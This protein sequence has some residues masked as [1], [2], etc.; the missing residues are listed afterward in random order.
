MNKTTLIRTLIQNSGSTIIS[1]EFLKKDGNTRKVQFNPLDRQEIKGFAGST[2]QDENIIRIR[3]FAIARKKG[4][5]AWRSFDCSR[6]LSI[7]TNGQKI[8]F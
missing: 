2:C 6:V 8:T 4:N 1:V 3:D 5:G 7:T